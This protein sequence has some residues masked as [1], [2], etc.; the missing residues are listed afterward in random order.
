MTTSPRTDGPTPLRRSDRTPQL[1][2]WLNPAARAQLERDLDD[3]PDLADQ[4][5]QHY[6]DLLAHPTRSPD[7]PWIRYPIDAHPLDL[8]DR[9]SKGPG[10]DPIGEA[11][12]ARRIGARRA[13]I[14][15][16]LGSWVRLAEG[17]MLDLDVSHTDPADQPTV[18]T[19]AGWLSQHL[20][21]IGGQQWVTELAHDVRGLAA[22]L[23]QL[24]GPAYAEPDHSATATITELAASTGIPAQTIYRWVHLG[25]LVPVT[26]IRPR[27]FMRC[28]VIALR[29]ANA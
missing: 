18:T 20:D 23:T 13:G 15:P 27:H 24:I 5:D 12:L 8:A 16:T 22:D 11:D 9:R 10:L 14:L 17:E 19:E 28:E 26:D 25:Y 2:A 1:A 7:D 6:D 21:W 4:L 3:L 29:G